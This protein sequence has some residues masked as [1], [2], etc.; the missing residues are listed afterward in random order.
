MTFDTFAPVHCD[1]EMTDV[2]MI[3]IHQVT[4]G[5]APVA[6][7]SSGCSLSRVYSPALDIVNG[8]LKGEYV[9]QPLFQHSGNS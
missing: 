1:T 3:A 2:P 5:D 6:A 7:P 8:L 9:I 4:D